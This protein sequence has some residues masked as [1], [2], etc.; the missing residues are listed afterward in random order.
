MTTSLIRQAPEDTMFVGGLHWRITQ[1]RSSVGTRLYRHLVS[2]GGEKV[3]RSLVMALQPDEAQA[4]SQTRAEMW[5]ADEAMR[6]IRDAS[7]GKTVAE[8]D[9]VQLQLAFAA[10]VA[11][12]SIEKV[13]DIGRELLWESQLMCSRQPKVF[14]GPDTFGADRSSRP[15]WEDELDCIIPDVATRTRLEVWAFLLLCRPSSAGSR[16][17]R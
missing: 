6:I 12:H 14:T 5:G 11:P 9:L 13:S 7:L 1:P 8:A 17:A 10:L 4:D 15:T 16:T 2:L 3:I